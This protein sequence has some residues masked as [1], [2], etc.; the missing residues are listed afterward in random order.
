MREFIAEAERF[1]S[2]PLGPALAVM[3]SDGGV[4]EPNEWDYHDLRLTIRDPDEAGG[5]A[6]NLS[7]TVPGRP[8][9][10]C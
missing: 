3:A 6:G 5:V 7:L 2:C 10:E 1:A 9:R 4:C 8:S